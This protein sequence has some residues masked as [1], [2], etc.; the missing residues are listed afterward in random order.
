MLEEEDKKYLSL[1]RINLIERLVKSE[2]SIPVPFLC[3]ICKKTMFVD[4]RGNFYCYCG[5]ED[6][7]DF[8]LAEFGTA[9]D[10]GE[11]FENYVKLVEKWQGG[12]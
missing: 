5:Y 9:D 4:T 12:C 6:R 1:W 2:R 8:Y 11:K 10:N 7:L 3:K